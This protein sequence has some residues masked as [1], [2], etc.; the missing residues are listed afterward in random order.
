MKK[1]RVLCGVAAAVFAA[2]IWSRTTAPGLAQTTCPAGQPAI[3]SP[4]PG[5]VPTQDCAGW[6]PANYPAALGQPPLTTERARIARGLEIA[7]VPLNLQGLDRDLVGLGSYLVNGP[8]GCNG[9]HTSPAFL[10]DGDPFLGQPTAIN[11]AGYLAGGAEFGPFVSRNITPDASGQPAGLSYDQFLQVMRQGTDFKHL[12]PPV[13]SPSLDLLQVMPWPEFR[14][15][16]D[17][18]IRAMY[19]YLRAVPRR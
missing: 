3:P 7:P 11:V 8:G 10:P 14:Y 15:M 6:V 2:A 19:E 17:S 4:G 1:W 16:I 13:P 5:F 12:P 18:D 9:C